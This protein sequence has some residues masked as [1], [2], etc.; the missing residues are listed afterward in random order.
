MNGQLLSA[1]CF[2]ILFHDVEAKKICKL[3][4]PIILRSNDGTIN[5]L[6]IEGCI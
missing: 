5:F 4:L 2:S 1:V 6:K 3:F